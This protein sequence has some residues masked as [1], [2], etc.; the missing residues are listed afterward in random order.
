MMSLES[1]PKRTRKEVVSFLELQAAFELANTRPVTLGDIE[2][3]AR[4]LADLLKPK[5]IKS[6]RDRV[7]YELARAVADALQ[8]RVLAH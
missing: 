3:K 1:L 7:L 8:E 2:A 5:A 6:H 4:R